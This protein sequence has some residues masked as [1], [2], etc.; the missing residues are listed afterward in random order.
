MPQSDQSQASGS[1][2]FLMV[3]LQKGG[4]WGAV[5]I[6]IASLGEFALGI[7]T[8]A[9]FHDLM[10]GMEYFAHGLVWMG[11]SVAL[12]AIAWHSNRAT[13]MI[14]TSQAENKIENPHLTAASSDP[15]IQSAIDKITAA[16][17]AKA[18]EAARHT[19]P[20]GTP[21]T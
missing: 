20:L 9:K 7:S 11:A 3:V 2:G 1:V 18:A 4:K 17:P 8:V 5:G 10:A 19:P 16:D 13:Q 12:L 21:I 14:A 15:A 6:F